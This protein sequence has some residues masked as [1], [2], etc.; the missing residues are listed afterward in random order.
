M[1]RTVIQK[2]WYNHPKPR[3]FSPTCVAVIRKHRP[4]HGCRKNEVRIIIPITCTWSV[5]NNIRHNHPNNMRWSSE[6]HD[7]NRSRFNMPYY[8]IGKNECQYDVIGFYSPPPPPPCPPPPLSCPW[9]CRLICPPPPPLS[10]PRFHPTYRNPSTPLHPPPHYQP[11]PL[12]APKGIPTPPLRTLQLVKLPPLP[13]PSPAPPHINQ[14][15]QPLC[16]PTYQ[17]IWP[18]RDR[19]GGAWG[20]HTF[21]YFVLDHPLRRIKIIKKW[22]RHFPGGTGGPAPDAQRH[23]PLYFE[24]FIRAISDMT[25]PC[26]FNNE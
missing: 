23:L 2:T 8:G 9:A 16:H 13:H 15:G 14:R 10:D 3:F 20:Y 24:I 22:N 19:A 11:P 1:L 5:P 17:R 26:F 4:A 12:L 25:S 21:L 18:V 6:K 7:H